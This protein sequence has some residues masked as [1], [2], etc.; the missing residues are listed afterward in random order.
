MRKNCSIFQGGYRER[1]CGFAV[2]YN[3]SWSS[4]NI[5]KDISIATGMG[6]SGAYFCRERQIQHQSTAAYWKNA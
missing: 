4:Y 1:T 2:I 6:R 5:D 3:G